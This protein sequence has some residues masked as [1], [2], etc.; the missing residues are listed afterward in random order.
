MDSD[1]LLKQYQ[2]IPCNTPSLASPDCE[3]GIVDAIVGNATFSQAKGGFCH[4][5]GHIAEIRLNRGLASIV[6]ASLYP[7]AR[8]PDQH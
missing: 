1:S 4:L 8:W 6:P 2:L 5:A 7:A 3:K